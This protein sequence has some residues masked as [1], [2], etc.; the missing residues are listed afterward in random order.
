MFNKSLAAILLL[1]GTAL[2]VQPVL[3]QDS[4]SEAAPQ[5]TAPQEANEDTVIARVDGEDIRQSDLIA[6]IQTLPPQLQSQAQ[7]LM[8]QLVDQL[9]NNALV[10]GAGRKADLAEDGE[11]RARMTELESIIIRQVYVQRTIDAR[12]TDAKVVEA[13]EA[14]LAEN[15]PE[16]Q[17]TARHILVEE[18]EAAKALIVELDGGADFATLADAHSKD[19]GAGGQLPPFV[20]GDMVAEF[21]DAAFAMEVGSYSAAPVQTQFGYHII[22]IEERSMTEPPS[23]EALDRQLRDQAAQEVVQELYAEL[24][25]QA[26]VEVLLGRPA[27]EAES[28]PETAPESAE[29]PASEPAA[30][31]E[32]NN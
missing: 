12:V 5:E 8:P 30:A 17:L 20:K 32:T 26:E 1:S 18:E 23:I 2:A 15:P 3:A 22:K 24:R 16:A 7:F 19:S 28:A 9:V 21:G 13:Y 11:V 27:P 6:F 31:P 14:Y 29:E 10:T 25:G 4:S